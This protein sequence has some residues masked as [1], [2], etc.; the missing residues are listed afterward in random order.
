MKPK[1]RRLAV[2]LPEDQLAELKQLHKNILESKS[3]AALVGLPDAS[4][5]KS[6]L[7]GTLK[8]AVI[9]SHTDR[10]PWPLN[11]KKKKK[12]KKQSLKP[13]SLP[14]SEPVSQPTRKRM[15]RVDKALALAGVKSSAPKQTKADLQIKVSFEKHSVNIVDKKHGQLILKVRRGCLLKTIGHCSVC[16]IS[17]APLTRYADSNYGPVALCSMCKVDAFEASF[18]H[19]DAM[20]LKIDHAHAYR[21]KW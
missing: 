1:T 11:N 15:S 12:P 19:A 9:P 21:G 7:S 4:S 17:M 6:S 3:S 16:F 20:P 18:G 8:L 14:V 10:K 2:S 13:P 5:K